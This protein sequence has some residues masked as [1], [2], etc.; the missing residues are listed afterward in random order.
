MCE[1]ISRDW[2]CIQNAGLGDSNSTQ[3]VGIW[4][5][6]KINHKLSFTSLPS[7]FFFKR[8]RPQAFCN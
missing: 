7:S 5:A 3:N 6:T 1:N 8:N 2:G 4:K